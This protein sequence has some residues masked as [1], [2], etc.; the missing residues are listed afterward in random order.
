MDIRALKERVCLRS[1]EVFGSTGWT[2]VA[3]D[4]LAWQYIQNDWNNHHWPVLHGLFPEGG[5]TVI[6]A[7]GNGGMYPLFLSQLFQRVY[8]FEPDPVMFH[9][10]VNNCQDE[11]I[12]T[13]Q[14]ALGSHAGFIDI[15]QFCP[16][17]CG[18]Q[19]VGEVKKNSIPMFTIDQFLFNDVDLI[20]LD[21]EG[22]EL[23]ILEGAI[24]T[25]N[26]FH[27]KVIAEL[28]NLESDDI[29][30]YTDV[31]AFMGKLGYPEPK[32]IGHRDFLFV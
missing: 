5:K 13:L 9:C 15:A 28:S 30:Q 3:G 10:M 31:V 11:R 25:L 12:I 24:H 22:Y 29:Q 6:Q 7:G 19:V 32:R 21:T 1:D 27:P 2:W 26:E 20:F 23:N 8:T 16:D 18:M 14:G 17:N 4:D